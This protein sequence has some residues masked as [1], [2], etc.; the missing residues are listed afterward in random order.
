MILLTPSIIT[1]HL[2]LKLQ[3]KTIKHSHKHFS[4]YL[5]NKNGSTMFRQPTDKNEIATIISFFVSNKSFAPD[6]IPYRVLFLLK[7]EI[8]KH[9]ADLFNLSFMV[10]VF[11]SVPK[12]ARVV[13]VFDKDSKLNYSNY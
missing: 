9:L 2:Q 12:I 13:P 3:E 4:D 10:S 5:G 1:L 6:S 11:P 7:I 8:S